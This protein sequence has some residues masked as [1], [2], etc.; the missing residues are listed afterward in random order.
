IIF[1]SSELIP[2]GSPYN[3]TEEDVEIFYE[4]LSTLLRFLAERG[5]EGRT[6]REFH[7]EWVAGE[8]A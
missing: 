3:S 2:G 4:N 5:V 1:H 8:R 6:F 7:D